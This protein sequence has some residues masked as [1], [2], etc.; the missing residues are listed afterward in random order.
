MT[1]KIKAL[2]ALSAVALFLSSVWSAHVL[3]VGP[4][5]WDKHGQIGEFFS[6]FYERATYNYLMLVLIACAFFAWATYVKHSRSRHAI[7]RLLDSIVAEVMNTPQTF[8]TQ[9]FR[10]TLYVHKKYSF[11][12]FF[13]QDWAKKLIRFKAVHYKGWL[14]PYARSGDDRKG[15][16]CFRAPLVASQGQ[17]SGHGVCG[18]AWI[19][20][21]CYVSALPQLTDASG[22]AQRRKYAERAHMT[23]EDVCQ[24]LR[25][26]RSLA[27]SYWAERISTTRAPKWGVLV[28]DSVGSAPVIDEGNK[29]AHSLALQAVSLL[30]EEYQL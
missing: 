2:E 9:D 18:T 25:D 12:G 5:P 7:Y 3:D 28:Y 1:R 17:N 14:V 30:L 10:V 21:E 23:F 4:R 29:K 24:R 19:L 16:S 15:G 6:T 22:E 20:G 13:D 11:R 27:L 26:K 8:N